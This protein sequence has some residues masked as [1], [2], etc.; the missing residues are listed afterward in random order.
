MLCYYTQ[1]VT[2]HPVETKCWYEFQQLQRFEF[3][4]HYCIGQVNGFIG[5]SLE[6]FIWNDI[7]RIQGKD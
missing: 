5:E 6:Q 1:I 3:S 2:R 7:I 4:L